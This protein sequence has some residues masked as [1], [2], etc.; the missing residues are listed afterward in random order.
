MAEKKSN[1]FVDNKRFQELMVERR[2]Q[3]EENNGVPPRVNDEIGLIFS[4]IAEKLTFHKYFIAIT[5]NDELVKDEMIGDA[6]ENCIRYI[7]CYDS[8]TYD[9]PFAYFT[10]ISYFAFQRRKAKEKK[11][12]DGT[13]DY[14]AELEIINGLPTSKCAFAQSIVD[15]FCKE[16]PGDD[17]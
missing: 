9:N 8:M 7:D 13:K 4:T 10:Q 16:T 15:D 6:I 3:T 1:Y 2:I 12:I 5:L 11:R 14:Y 17:N